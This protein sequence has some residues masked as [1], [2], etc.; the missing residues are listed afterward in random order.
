MNPPTI[1]KTWTKSA[2]RP[3]RST[4][5]ALG[6]WLLSRLLGVPVP[7]RAIHQTD[8]AALLA[9][10][11]QRLLAL[12]AAGEQVPPVLS[13]DGRQLTTGDV[14][15][16]LEHLLHRIPE[17]ERLP[18]MCAAAADLAGFHARGHWHG[19]AQAR[20]LTWDGRRFARLD[21]EECLHP[22]LP[23]P[24]VQLY[25]ALQLVM[26][27]ARFLEPL[28]A[29]AVFEV[30]QAYRRAGAGGVPDL[31]AFVRRLLPRLQWVARMAGWSSRLDG[32]REVR[33]LRTVLD[34]MRAFVDAPQVR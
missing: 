28:G 23:L 12:A 30:L 33:R 31:A 26:S 10:E 22:P 3:L 25:D 11:H 8:G 15:H 13:F 1:P 5:N 14:G 18:L 24:T 29:Q 21:F 2:Q 17:A 19:G 34:G 4:G 9:Y 6:V 32:S 7:W 20:N 16:T 27:L